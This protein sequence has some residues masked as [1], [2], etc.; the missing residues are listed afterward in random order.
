MKKVTVFFCGWGQRWPLGTL[1]DNGK[2]LLF[3]YSPEAIAHGIELSP[4]H[5]KLRAEAYGGFPGYQD[6]LPGLIADALPDGWGL[7]LMDRVFKKHFSLDPHQISPLDRLAYIGDRA[8]GALTFEPAAIIDLPSPDIEI[9]TL[10]Q[11]VQAIVADRDTAALRQLLVIG[12]SPQGAR[13]KALVQYDAATDFISTREAA[14]GL[15]WLIKF[16]G[17][18]EHKEV[19]AIEHCYARLAADC[20]LDVPETR[21]FDLGTAYAA[22]GIERFDRQAGQRVP[23][24]TLAGALHADFRV[25]NAS[26]QTLLRSA[27]FFTRSEREVKKAFERCVFNV[28]FN[29]RDDHT[30]NFSFRMDETFSWKLAPCYDLT[31]CEGPGGYHQMDIEG[32]ALRPSRADLIKLAA[33]NNLDTGWASDRIERF[34]SIGSQF[35]TFA[36]DYVIRA[37]TRNKIA[38]AIGENIKRMGTRRVKPV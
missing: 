5:L 38:K 13:P 2:E 27:Q 12:G 6:K 14:P 26:Y 7:L 35:K 18:S 4:R 29:N 34:A 17:K 20:G 3:E 16:P 30:K 33:S 8:M 21:Y 36:N 37:S 31:F 1:A 25:A 11:E 9:V 32:E 28:V 19:C 15:P 23:T 10:A 22:F 24:H